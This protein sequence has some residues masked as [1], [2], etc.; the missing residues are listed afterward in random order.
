MVWRSNPQSAKGIFK[1]RNLFLKF[2]IIFCDIRKILPKF[3]FDHKK[4]KIFLEKVKLIFSTFFKTKT[5]LE[6]KS[7]FKMTS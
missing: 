7:C 2:K 5:H 6:D 3:S 1:A 4:R